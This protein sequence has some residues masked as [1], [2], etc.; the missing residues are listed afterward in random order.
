MSAIAWASRRPQNAAFVWTA[1]IANAIRIADPG[2]PVVSGMHSLSSATTNTG[3][4]WRI[5]DQAALTDILTT[6]PYPSW[7]RHTNTF[8]RPIGSRNLLPIVCEVN[9]LSR[10]LCYLG[11][12][13]PKAAGTRAP[14]SKRFHACSMSRTKLSSP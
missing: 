1:T 3:N 10:H 9:E 7:V 5:E 11:C 12:Q 14:S 13:L 8:D 2:R 6:H 4:P